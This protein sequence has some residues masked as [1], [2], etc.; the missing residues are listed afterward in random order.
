MSEEEFP[1]RSYEAHEKQFRRYAFGDSK[2]D[3]GSTW[4]KE[5]SVDQWRHERMRRSV[6][7]LIDA[8][9]DAKWLTVGDGRYGTDA[10]FLKGRGLSVV[11][12]DICD[13]LLAVGKRDGFI[14]D[15]SK[16]NAERLSFH[17]DEFD[18]CLCKE[19]YHHFPRAMVALHEML[20]V[21]KKGVALIEPNDQ[22][23][24]DSMRGLFFRKLKDAL[25]P[26]LGRNSPRH[27]FEEVGNYVYSISKREMEKVAAGMNY[28]LVAFK[29]LNDYYEKG[30]EQEPATLRNFKYNKVR[31]KILLKNIFCNLGL[32][33]PNMLVAFILKEK[34]AKSLLDRMIREN[35]DVFEIPKNPYI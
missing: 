4:M 1:R 2:G 34:P 13:E 32:N 23:V 29:G 10:H 35:F 17:D 5:G 19:A 3:I 27:A 30:V 15:Y 31:M 14:D 28:K 12:S 25:K 20:R 8:F 21:S 7:P 16:Q 26:P 6:L 11:A 24:F 9:P 33:M 18:F 22:F